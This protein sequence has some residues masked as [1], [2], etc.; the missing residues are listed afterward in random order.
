MNEVVV[1]IFISG[2]GVRENVGE[3]VVTC[4]KKADIMERPN[5]INIGTNR[6]NS[7]LAEN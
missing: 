1:R 7:L 5:I 4:C 2:V 3:V 6:K